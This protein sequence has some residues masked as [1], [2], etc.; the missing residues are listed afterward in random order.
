MIALIVFHFY[1]ITCTHLSQDDKRSYRNY[2]ENMFTVTRG[3][4]HSDTQN[5]EHV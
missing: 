4:S 5:N 2:V 1:Q 3:E